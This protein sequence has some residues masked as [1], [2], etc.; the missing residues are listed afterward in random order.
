[1]ST[2]PSLPPEIWTTLT[3]PIDADMVRRVFAAGQI[4]VNGGVKKLH[5]LI[6]SSGGTVGDAIALYNFL[7][8]LPMEVITYNAGSVLSAAV[9]TY[10]AGKVRK[11]SKAATF[12]IHKSTLTLPAPTTAERLKMSA[13]GLLIEDARSEAV[14][15]EHLRLPSKSWKIHQR[16]ELILTAGESIKIGL[17]HEIGDWAPPS[18][19]RLFSI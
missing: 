3:G 2:P 6:H 10:L 1:M 14:L 15:R 12:M 4:A 16:G 9:I 5:L 13:E 7:R 19:A 18:G 17:A 8:S 11:V